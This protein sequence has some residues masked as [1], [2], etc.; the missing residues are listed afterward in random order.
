MIVQYH[1]I[2]LAATFG[3]AMAFTLSCSSGSDDPP[4]GGGDSSVIGGADGGGNQF[5]QIY[6][7]HGGHWGDDD[8][9]HYQIGEAYKG[10]GIIEI[11]DGVGCFG[12]MG[13]WSCKFHDGGLKAGNVTNGI[14][15]LE[16]PNNIPNEYLHALNVQEQECSSFDKDIKYGTRLE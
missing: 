12:G 4:N 1:K 15:K 6:Y 9:F 8:I 3:L 7:T 16:L 10:S 13:G 2:A 5:S 14:V 11:V